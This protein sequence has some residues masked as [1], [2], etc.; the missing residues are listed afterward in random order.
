MKRVVTLL[1]CIAVSI[2]LIT[3][4]MLSLYTNEKEKN[5]KLDGEIDKITDEIKSTSENNSKIELELEELKENNKDKVTELEVW[6][7]TRE[8]IE[9]GL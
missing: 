7:K 4:F 5:I 6:K 2:F 3:I 8:T 1:S 9:K